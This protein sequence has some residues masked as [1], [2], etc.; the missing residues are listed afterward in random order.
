MAKKTK[1]QLERDVREF[2]R[3]GKG[4]KQM[5]AESVGMEYIASRPIARVDVDYGADP[6]GDG[7]YR[8]VPSG[9]IVDYEERMRRLP[10]R[11]LRSGR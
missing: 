2:L 11:P 7:M 8:M 5:M 9:D 4:Q 1:T 6:I 3:T 10:A